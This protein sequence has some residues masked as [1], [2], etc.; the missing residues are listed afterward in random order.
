MDTFRTIQP[1]INDIHKRLQDE[2]E[3]EELEEKDPNILNIGIIRDYHKILN[4][5]DR[6]IQVRFDIYFRNNILSP[7]IYY[8]NKK[9]QQNY[10]N[11][12][13]NDKYYKHFLRLTSL[14]FIDKSL[15]NNDYNFLNKYV[16]NIKMKYLYVLDPLN[17]NINSIGVNNEFNSCLSLCDE[18]LNKLRLDNYNK[19]LELLNNHN[20]SKLLNNHNNKFGG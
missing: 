8:D 11:I 9:L 5:I 14:E 10:R 12:L 15:S 19:Q 17:T 2:R 13:F 20:K 4:D 3:L 18:S 6:N 7:E 1:I 16:A